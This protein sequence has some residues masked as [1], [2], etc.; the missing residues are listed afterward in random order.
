MCGEIL[1]WILDEKRVIEC[2]LDCP[3]RQYCYLLGYVICDCGSSCRVLSLCESMHAMVFIPSCH[4]NAYLT[5][6]AGSVISAV[7]L[8]TKTTSIM[9]YGVIRSVL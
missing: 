1:G 6:C 9:C 2:F 5:K 3:L 8:S 4:F 7:T